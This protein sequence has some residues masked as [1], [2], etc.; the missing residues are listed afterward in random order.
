MSAPGHIGG[1][2]FRLKLR[3]VV[4]WCGDYH[5]ATGKGRFPPP[6]LPF[7]GSGI[8]CPVEG[9]TLASR[10]AYRYD[11]DGMRAL[12]VLAVIFCHLEIAVFHGGFIGVDVFF[13]ISGF[14]IT[15]ILHSEYKKT[16]TIALRSF[17][18][19]R[20][21]RLY[22]AL[23][24]T[25]VLTIGAGF[26]L[27]SAER[28]AALQASSAAAILS[29]SNI[30]FWSEV[31]YFDTDAAL[32][33]LLHT[34]SLGVEEQFYLLWPFFLLLLHRLG[35][36]RALIIGIAAI[37]LLT[38]AL[39]AYFFNL[40]PDSGL[41]TVEGFA[42]NISNG[43]SSAFYLFPFR[44]FEFGIGALVAFLPRPGAGEDGA[45]P[46]PLLFDM[47]AGA[48]AIALVALCIVLTEESVFPYY[49]ALW[50][51][52]ATALLIWAMPGGRVVQAIFASRVPVFLGRI[53]YSLYLVHWPLIVFSKS[54]VPDLTWPGR[55]LL[56]AGMIGLATL[57]YQFVETP[58]RKASFWRRPTYSVRDFFTKAV[59]PGVSV[60]VAFGVFAL[61]NESRIPEA[62]RTI[63]NNTWRKI[64]WERYCETPIPGIP[65][66]L[67][68]CQNNR[69]ADFTILVW[70]D[71]HARHH[72]SGLSETYPDANIAVSYFSG[73]PPISGLRGIEHRYE[74]AK[75][76]Q[77]CAD[78]NRALHEALLDGTLAP[79]VLL[80]TG[81]KFLQPND[82]FELER[83]AAPITIQI[84]DE[85]RANG[86]RTWYLGD[87][88][89]PGRVLGDCQS[90]PGF[91]LSKKLLASACKPVAE[92]V[93][94]ELVY[95]G[96][97]GELL[98]DRYI[99]LHQVQCPDG[100]CAFVTG[101]GHPSH[102]DDH[103]LSIP[104]SVELTRKAD[105]MMRETVPALS[106]VRTDNSPFAFAPPP[107]QI[108][109]DIACPEPIGST[110]PFR[111][112]F[113]FT[114]DTEGV[115]TFDN[116]SAADPLRSYDRYKLDLRTPGIA[117]ISGEY[118][119]GRGRVSPAEFTGTQSR[120][121]FRVDG[122]RG[123]RTCYAEGP[124]P[125]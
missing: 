38:Y 8:Q 99:P 24:V 39:N 10:I 57:M 76:Q 102:R 67:V 117:T 16:G 114:E 11:I 43:P 77:D 36:R 103:H 68:N 37:S 54:F 15:S 86:V 107:R 73:C 104:G 91:I 4:P 115:F 28:F 94:A 97:M 92:E 108:S 109:I 121:G 111:Q 60:A 82:T 75:R 27:L 95:A 85:L 101:S 35:G 72:I 63:D 19:R 18:W 79:D 62:R 78:T 123:P 81:R 80:L 12:A 87:V 49:N 119:R 46:R 48:A 93:E 88:I 118:Q 58:F 100:A 116:A 33:P 105:A 29:V 13:V 52:L 65:E 74:D 32:K 34:W 45:A 44:I 23:I 21:Q 113:T 122:K 112:S 64:E 3:L 9:F 84:I 120:K 110:A 50:V 14:L 124:L 96:R 47:L 30:W 31:G 69:D 40:P 7:Q 41:N 22:P 51:C 53:S 90:V 6:L 71:S 5:A 61:P 106:S 20:M 17:Y 25:V 125:G 83:D 98:G 2:G 89:R 59:L 1:A 56:F 66:L 70:G 26:L 55:I 42:A